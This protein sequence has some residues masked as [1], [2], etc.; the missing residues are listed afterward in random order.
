MKKRVLS[1]FMALA[2]CFS[3]LPTAALAEEAG[4]VQDAANANSTYTTG[5][6]ARLPKLLSAT[7]PKSRMPRQRRTSQ[8]PR[9]RR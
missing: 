6:G 7:M 5:E 9:C 8:R 2:L 4:A 1:L 3:M